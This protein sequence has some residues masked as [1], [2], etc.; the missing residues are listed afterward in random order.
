MTDWLIGMVV[1]LPCDPRE[2]CQF[3]HTDC[4]RDMT[5]T[6]LNATYRP[7]SEFVAS[8]TWNQWSLVGSSLRAVMVSQ[9]THFM[10]DTGLLT[11]D[12]E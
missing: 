7:N 10:N 9:C 2:Q 8:R 11:Q 5:E 12:Q 6:M 3:P 1:A 4:C